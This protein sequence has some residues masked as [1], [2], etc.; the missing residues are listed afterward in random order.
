MSRRIEIAVFLYDGMTTL[1]AVG[2]YE[3]PIFAQVP[4]GNVAALRA[5][6]AA[7]F[8]PIGG[9]ERRLPARAMGSI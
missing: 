8:R 1:D 5:F 2:P 6:P 4:P 7:G 3:V 9:E